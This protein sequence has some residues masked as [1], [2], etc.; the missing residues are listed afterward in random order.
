[1]PLPMVGWTGHC[2]NFRTTSRSLN[3]DGTPALSK[4]ER[5]IE[6]ADR[7]DDGAPQGLAAGSTISR[8]RTATSKAG[9]GRQQS[10]GLARAAYDRV[11]DVLGTLRKRGSW[12]G[13]RCSI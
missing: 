13:T 10:G 11:T 6:I 3:S 9:H 8:C 7:D 2:P 12:G 5:L 1:M 4:A